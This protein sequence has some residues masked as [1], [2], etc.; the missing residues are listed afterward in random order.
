MAHGKRD[1][2]PDP[3]MR[4]VVEVTQDEYRRLQRG[5]PGHSVADFLRVAG[6]RIA[7]LRAAELER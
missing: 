6:V 4:I 7:D 3:P 1:P 5:A 2:V